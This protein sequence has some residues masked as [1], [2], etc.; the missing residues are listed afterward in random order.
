MLVRLAAV[1]V[2]A[3]ASAR[4]VEGRE[5]VDRR[6]RDRAPV[7]DARAVGKW[8]LA[9][10]VDPA[11]ADMLRGARRGRRP[12][13]AATPRPRRRSS[14]E[15][16]FSREASATRAL[17]P[18]ARAGIVYATE[19]SDEASETQLPMLAQSAFSA[20]PRPRQKSP[21]MLFRPPPR[22]IHV[23]A[24]A[25]PRP[26][27][28]EAARFLRRRTVGPRASPFRRGRSK[29]PPSDAVRSKRPPSDAVEA[30]AL[31]PTQ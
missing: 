13:V 4:P 21:E 17:S 26:A 11:P 25:S 12:P 1:V 2:A 24:A 5:V 10:A 19:H 9:D 14:A 15:K 27:S 18:S 23:A 22:N 20:Y 28:A 8:D 3:A 6:L 7:E 29:R 16:S 30:N 31:L